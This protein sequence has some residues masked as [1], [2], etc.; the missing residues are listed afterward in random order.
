MMI[1]DARWEGSHGIGR[2]ASELRNRLT[3]FSSASLEGRPSHPL[4][5]FVLYRYL[6]RVTPSLFFSPGYNPPVGRP[7]PFVFCV[8]DLNHLYVRENSSVLKRAYYR[9][10]VRPAIHRAQR[11]VTGSEFSRS[12]ICEWSGAEASQIVAVGYGVSDAFILNGPRHGARNRPYF[13][14]VGNQKIHKNTM[15]T[16]QA[17][18][19]AFKN[20]EFL[21]LCTGMP[22]PQLQLEVERLG[23]GKQVEFVGAVSDEK[24]ARLYRGALALAFVSLYEG[25]GLPIIESMACGTP[26]LTSTNTAMPEV[27]GSA[28]V[29]VDPYDVD[30]IAH[31]MRRLA[32]D[33]ELRQDLRDQGLQRSKLFSWEQ[34]SMKVR[35]AIAT[36]A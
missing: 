31:G 4:D 24:L 14:C 18:A 32:D 6:K 36:C 12:Q 11:V 16:M 2:F 33:S 35:K 25:F 9:Y 30:A 15:R 27:A 7:C 17:F 19:S 20:T 1:F 3:E 28:A 26:V 13:L 5:P 21:L 34:T 29:L 10:I 22:S 8:H 23:I